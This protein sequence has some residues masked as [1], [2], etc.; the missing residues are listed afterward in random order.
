MDSYKDKL[1]YSIP[2]AVL[3]TGIKRSKLYQEIREGRL[4]VRKVGKRTLVTADAIKNWLKA[5]PSSHT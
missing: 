4:E 3:A 5:L 1:S 2:E